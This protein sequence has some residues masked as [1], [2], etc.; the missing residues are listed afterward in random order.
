[1]KLTLNLTNK[2]YNTIK[3]ISNIDYSDR[4]Y[5]DTFVFTGIISNKIKD[6]NS[7]SKKH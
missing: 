4:T 6:G 3:K 1:M 7:R 5:F 2:E